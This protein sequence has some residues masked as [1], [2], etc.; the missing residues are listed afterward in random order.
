MPESVEED[1][2]HGAA[3]AQTDQSQHG[4]TIRHQR[5]RGGKLDQVLA[6]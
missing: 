5:D 2:E 3:E 6:N 4:E 1:R